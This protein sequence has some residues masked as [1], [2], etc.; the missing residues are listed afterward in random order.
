MACRLR[1]DRLS[2]KDDEAKDD[3]TAC[4][5]AVAML[6]LPQTAEY[7]LRA[8]YFIA[9]AA[10]DAPVGVEA[11]AAATKIPRNYLSKTLYQLV[12]AGVLSSTR[13]PRGGFWLAKLPSRIALAEIIRPFLPP[14]GRVCV[15]G[16]ATC[17][18]AAP[19][20]AHERWKA[21]AQPMRGFFAHTTVAD[22]VDAPAA[23]D[24]PAA[25]TATARRRPPRGTPRSS[26]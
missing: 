20:A 13:G 3:E 21:V 8:V 18:D 12:G 1:P 17:S 24:T 14:E 2:Y 19:C 5:P 22:L 25:R 4:A 11:I 7:A 15:L 23:P 10:E 26:D 16:R 9:E 6:R